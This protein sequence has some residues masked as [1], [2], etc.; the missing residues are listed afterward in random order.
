VQ[1]PRSPRP[2]DVSTTGDEQGARELPQLDEPRFE[3]DRIARRAYE[4]YEARGRE[5][6]RDMEDWF[7][8]ERELR[9]S[10]SSTDTAR[11]DGGSTVRINQ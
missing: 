3:P 9:Q 11:S 6:G 7:E 5:D 10:A 1:M 2:A 4:R 8:A